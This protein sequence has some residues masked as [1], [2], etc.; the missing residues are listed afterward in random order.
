[1]R[2]KIRV[3]IS[4]LYEKVLKNIFMKLYVYVYKEK[5]IIYHGSTFSQMYHIERNIIC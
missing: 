4:T 1:M 3:F 5:N 2:W